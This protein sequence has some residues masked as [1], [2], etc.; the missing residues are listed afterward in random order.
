MLCVVGHWLV[1]LLL[2]QALGNGD[3]AE[4]EPKPAEPKPAEPE[5][6]EP[7]TVADAGADDAAAAADAG[8]A[9]SSSS[10]SSAPSPSSLSCQCES[11]DAAE[12]EAGEQ[13]QSAEDSQ[14]PAPAVESLTGQPQQELKLGPS[15]MQEARR[16]AYDPRQ[17][18]MHF[19]VSLCMCVHVHL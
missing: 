12:P 9:S 7:E 6:A 1:N 13:K 17:C 16:F 4:V 10:S 15:N 5:P 14:P 11:E 19:Q 2:L 8:A 18:I 3:G